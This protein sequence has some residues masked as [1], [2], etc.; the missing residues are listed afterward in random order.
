MKFK[1]RFRRVQYKPISPI[2]LIFLLLFMITMI[3]FIRGFQ[4]RLNAE[5]IEW[6]PTNR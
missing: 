1:R 3:I 2:Y 5:N 4:R 6:S